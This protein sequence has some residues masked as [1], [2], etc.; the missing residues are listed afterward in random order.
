MF[1]G[2]KNIIITLTAIEAML[3]AINMLLTLYPIYSD[4]LNGLLLLFRIL[5]IAAGET[6]IG[7]S[8]IISYHKLANE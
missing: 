1:L 6:A 3:L 2:R 7:L 4:D 8:L 5:P